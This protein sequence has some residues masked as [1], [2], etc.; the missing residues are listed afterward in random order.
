MK[1]DVPPLSTDLSTLVVLAYICP[2]M[3]LFK[4]FWKVQTMDE[5]WR[6]LTNLKKFLV[7]LY[8]ELEIPSGSRWVAIRMAGLYKTLDF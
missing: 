2:E 3:Y 5:D 1:S 6:P 4:Y 8:I 7:Q